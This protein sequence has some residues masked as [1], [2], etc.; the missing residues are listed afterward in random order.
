MTI[1]KHGK[2]RCMERLGVTED[3]I[4]LASYRA[5][6]E[7]LKLEET[8]D[9]LRGY[10]EW[11]S[12]RRSGNDRS[13]RVFGGYVFLFGGRKLI[14]VYSLPLEYRHMAIQQERRKYRMAQ[15]DKCRHGTVM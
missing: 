1:T 13:V 11:V 8:Y 12:K 14:T 15:R 2:Q 5:F 6:A 10:L 3:C 4:K 9:D 7:G